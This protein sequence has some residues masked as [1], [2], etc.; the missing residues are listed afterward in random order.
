MRS[1]RLRG[2][3]P[4]DEMVDRQETDVAINR[5]SNVLVYLIHGVTGT[6]VEMSYVAQKLSRKNRWDVYAT[7]LPGH[8]TRL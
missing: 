3:G 8:C 6:P 5:N 2:F 4:L 1:H 7:T